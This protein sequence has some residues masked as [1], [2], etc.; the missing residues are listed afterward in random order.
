L[1]WI[2]GDPGKGK[3]M[4][5]CGIVDELQ[6]SCAE[7][8]LLSFF[9]CQATDSRI[10]NATAV[11]RGLIYLILDQQ[12]SLIHHAR[13]KYDHAGKA[14]FGDANSWIALSEI[15]TNILQDPSLMSTY[16]VIDA[17]DECVTDLPKLLKLIVQKS[18][19]SSVKWIV[20]SRNW[21]NIEEG[22]SLHDS[23]MLLGLEL[24]QN[25]EQVSHAVDAYIDHCVSKLAAIHND[26]LLQDQVRQ[27]M[28]Q[29]ANGTFLWVS[30]IFKELE[31]ASSWEVQQVIGE[32]PEDLKD[33]YNRMVKQ[34]RG[35]KRQNPEL[36]RGVLAVATAAYRPLHLAELGILSGL[37]PGISSGHQHIMAIV[38]MCGSFLTMRDNIVYIIHQSAQDFLS[39]ETFLFPAGTTETHFDI[40]SRS[41]PAMSKT[42]YRDIY[43]LKY[44]GFPIN[45]LEHPEPDPLVAVRYSCVYWVD[46]LKDGAPTEN[47]TSDLQDGGSVE[48]S[49]VKPSCAG[50]RLSACF[51]VCRKEYL[52]WRSWIICF[53]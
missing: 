35:L 50:L 16:L 3:T 25:A 32:M 37:P 2:K 8:G 17:L 49:C 19:M 5:L 12:P 21:P 46:H 11:L 31:D 34:I 44:P 20:S 41:L 22:L 14:L 53:R 15:F 42:L 38:N 30:L 24:K 43:I 40:F 51:G 26:K 52:Q 9:F 33:V 28:R 23:R 6:S 7:V 36:C 39:A 27:Q 18:S 47:A 29:K 13:K 45:E 48:S 10:N 4:L 1:F